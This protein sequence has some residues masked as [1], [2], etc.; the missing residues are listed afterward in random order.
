M[1]VSAADDDDAVADDAVALMHAVSGGDYATEDASDVIVRISEINTPGLLIYDV[2]AM[3][4]SG[5]MLFTVRLNMASSKVV[6]VICAISEGT[7]QEN[8]DYI[9]LTGRLEIKPEKRRGR[10]ACRL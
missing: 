7:A 6:T 8:E 9:D 5:E 2:M 1:T 10:S 3:E 4:D